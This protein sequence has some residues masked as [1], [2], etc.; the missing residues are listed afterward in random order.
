M[1]TIKNI[2]M[3]EN[4]TN[5]GNFDD[6]EENIKTLNSLDCQCSCGCLNNSKCK[7][8]L[9]IQEKNSKEIE[10]MYNQISEE[11]KELFSENISLHMQMEILKKTLNSEQ[12]MQITS[13][14]K[15]IVDLEKK[16]SDLEKKKTDLIQEIENLK[17]NITINTKQTIK[18]ITKQ[19]HENKLTP[20]SV[21]QMY[22]H[23][24]AGKKCKTQIKNK[25]QNNNKTEN[26]ITPLNTIKNTHLQNKLMTN[27][28]LS[29][30]KNM[31]ILK[32]DNVV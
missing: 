7:S 32:D 22:K 27:Y 9:K 4:S 28:H 12:H 14:K 8:D 13:L 25:E 10:E 26:K 17:K 20:Q 16:N 15:K 24:A 2:F 1:S 6:N 5:I 30:N 18:Q 19:N 11:N 31:N 3:S 23:L 21:Y 29:K